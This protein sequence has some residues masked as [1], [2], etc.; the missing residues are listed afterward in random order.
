M[1]NSLEHY[2]EATDGAGKLMA[3]ARLL[4]RL[5]RLYRDIAPPHLAQASTLANYKS[6]TVVMHAHSGAIAAKLRQLATTLAEGFSKRGIEC[7]GVQV[8][9]QAP[10]NPEQS[11]H[12]TLKPLGAGA[13]GALEHLRDSL[14]NDDLRQAIEHL[15]THSARKE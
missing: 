4:V 12:P 14:P 10:D 6:G 2:L 13:F 7:N 8:K 11:H 1:Q 3:H 9:V 15:L 5:T